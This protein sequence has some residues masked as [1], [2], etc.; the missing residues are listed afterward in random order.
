MDSGRSTSSEN[1]EIED[2]EVINFLLRSKLAGHEAAF[3]E[4]KQ[5]LENEKSE[6]RVLQQTMND[7]ISIAV[8]SETSTDIINLKNEL[9]EKKEV[10]ANLEC[11]LNGLKQK[12]VD[13]EDM[14]VMNFLLRSKLN[15]HEAAFEEQNQAL[16]QEKSENCAKSRPGFCQGPLHHD[17]IA[18]LVKNYH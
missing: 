18:V 10:V 15:S 2:M 7:L 17:E 16:A 9:G 6:K 11:Q 14:E 1:M 4:Q 8:E 12:V 13:Q 5:A 3:E